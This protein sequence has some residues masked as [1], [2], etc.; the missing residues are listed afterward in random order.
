MITSVPTNFCDPARKNWNQQ[1]NDMV[2]NSWDKRTKIQ[3]K[4]KASVFFMRKYHLVMTNS[5]PWKDP[6]M[7]L[8]GK[9]SK[10]V[11]NSKAS[12]NFPVV[13]LDE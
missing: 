7:L 2:F 5:S 1:N 12:R 4:I 13:F 10:T 9:P 11:P 3:K 6:P 8:I